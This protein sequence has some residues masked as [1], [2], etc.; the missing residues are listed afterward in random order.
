MHLALRSF[1]LE[2]NA[3]IVVTMKLG[4]TISLQISLQCIT[5]LPGI[6]G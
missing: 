5:K 6:L 2:N 1:G 3:G 4:E